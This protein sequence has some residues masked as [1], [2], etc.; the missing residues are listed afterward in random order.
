QRFP[1]RGDDHLLDLPVESAHRPF[2]PLDAS[3]DDQEGDDGKEDQDGDARYAHEQGI[4]LQRGQPF[5]YLASAASS[6]STPE[7]EQIV[8]SQ[9]RTSAASAKIS[10][11]SRFRTASASSPTSS[12]NQR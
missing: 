5:P 12:V 2:L 11:R 6:R 3:P 9:A 10:A 8:Q 1:A 7:I 4:R